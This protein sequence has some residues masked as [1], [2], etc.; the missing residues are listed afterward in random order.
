MGNTCPTCPK[1]AVCPTCPSV[2]GSGGGT[3]GSTGSN[4]VQT[5]QK[6]GQLCNEKNLCDASLNL[7]CVSGRCKE[8]GATGSNPCLAREAT[9]YLGC[10]YAYG[11]SETRQ[12]QCGQDGGTSKFIGDG[13][14][15]GDPCK[16]PRGST[17]F[18]G[19]GYAYANFDSRQSQCG[20]DGGTTKF[21]GDGLETGG[22]PVKYD[23]ISRVSYRIKEQKTNYQ[24]YILIFLIIISLLVL[25]FNK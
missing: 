23:S 17:L 19:C 16:L 7:I 6:K 1:C 13:I 14:P 20:Q 2:G 5:K 21:I 9:L 15:N 25:Y 12:S 4:V 24:L 11:K 18:L 22:Q 3:G 10:G 8:E